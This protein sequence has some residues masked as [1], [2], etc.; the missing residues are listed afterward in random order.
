MGGGGVKMQ[1]F[2]FFDYFKSMFFSIPFNLECLD[3]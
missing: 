3:Y 1:V 2:E